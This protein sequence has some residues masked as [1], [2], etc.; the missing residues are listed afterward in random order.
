M[1]S[2]GHPGRY[3]LAITLGAVLAGGLVTL[4][5]FS[6]NPAGEYTW[7]YGLLATVRLSAAVLLVTFTVG[8]LTRLTGAG[9]TRPLLLNRRYLGIAFA[10]LHSYHLL[11]IVLWTMAFPELMDIT[12]LV[13]GGAAFVFAY[14][15]ALTSNDA[16]VRRLGRYWKWLHITGIYYLWAIMTLTFAGQDS[17][18]ARTCTALFLMA[19]LLRVA[20]MAKR[21]IA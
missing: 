11:F 6:Q 20:A 10:I 12:T 19:M 21:R 2:R 4:L 16:A 14:L 3:P 13:G 8:P 7:Q 18:T 15:M 1:A 17:W 9:W 5:A